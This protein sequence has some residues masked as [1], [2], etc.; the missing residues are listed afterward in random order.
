MSRQD[1]A[2]TQETTRPD[3]PA[4]R[5][6][7]V[8]GELLAKTRLGPP[9]APRVYS[10]SDAAQKEARLEGCLLAVVA[11]GSRALASD[12]SL[13]GEEAQLVLEVAGS[14]SAGWPWA[15]VINIVG[16]GIAENPEG[17]LTQILEISTADHTFR[18]LA[19]AYKIGA[20]VSVLPAAGR[21]CWEELKEDHSPD[22]TVQEIDSALDGAS[23]VAGD[24][25]RELVG[26]LRSGLE[27]PPG[28]GTDAARGIEHLG[29][30][31]RMVEG[32]ERFRHDADGPGAAP[33]APGAPG[34]PLAPGDPPAPG[35]SG[36][37][38]AA[39]PPPPPGPWRTSDRPSGPSWFPGM[40]NPT[41][42]N[43]PSHPL[44]DA[45]ESPAAP[46]ATAPEADERTGTTGITG[47]TATGGD[48]AASATTAGDKSHV[49]GE[50]QTIRGKRH[51]KRR[52]FGRSARSENRHFSSHPAITRSRPVHAQPLSAAEVIRNLLTWSPRTASA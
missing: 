35:E 26:A 47:I 1:G 33:L 30:D 13:V 20:W 8:S 50:S 4:A 46:V 12:I 41:D 44:P 18:F 6:R 11:E 25:P 43:G 10:A 23:A 42:A 27:E 9:P 32:S 22:D 40:P 31:G 15:D 28:L 5:P 49:A 3:S 21:N 19:P 51:A 52:L 7:I 48:G 38:V 34:A 36:Y 39:S 17:E 16:D 14:R 2:V 24:H 37:P 29:G 45:V